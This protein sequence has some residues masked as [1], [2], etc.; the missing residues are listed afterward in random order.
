MASQIDHPPG[1]G[2]FGLARGLLLASISLLVAFPLHAQEEAKEPVT[3]PSAPPPVEKI[4][5]SAVPDRAAA[6]SAQ[7]RQVRER[8]SPESDVDEVVRLFGEHSDNL[9]DQFDAPELSNLDYQSARM[10]DNLVQA[11]IAERKPAVRV[12]ESNPETCRGAFRGAQWRLR[13]LAE[14]WQLTLDEQAARRTAGR[15]RRR[16]SRARWQTSNS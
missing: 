2:A 1:R 14:P 11:W 6:V 5:A 12:G 13:A 3:A 8:I 10:L 9:E 16:G 7:L 4:V 15:D